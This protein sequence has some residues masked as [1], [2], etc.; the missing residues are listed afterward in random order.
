MGFN[1]DICG[2]VMIID[3]RKFIVCD[4]IYI[5]A[6]VGSQMPDLEYNK[7]QAIILRKEYL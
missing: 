6:T 3:G 5:G 2:N 4:P 7:A 1:E